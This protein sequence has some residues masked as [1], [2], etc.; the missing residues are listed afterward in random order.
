MKN[1]FVW[2]IDRVIVTYVNGVIV[3]N[4]PRDDPYIFEWSLRITFKLSIRGK[5]I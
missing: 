5:K 3:Q 2:Y 1:D 4:L